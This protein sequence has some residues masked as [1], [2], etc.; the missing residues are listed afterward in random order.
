M[1]KLDIIF[2]IIIFLIVSYS[3]YLRFNYPYLTETQ[4]FLKMIGL[5]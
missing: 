1:N 3:M 2:L 5:Y 4:L